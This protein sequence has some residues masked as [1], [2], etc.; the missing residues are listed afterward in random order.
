MS[1]FGPTSDVCP[2]KSNLRNVIRNR[3]LGG[4]DYLSTHT[5]QSC[6]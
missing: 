1:A 3:S 2:A 5:K 6:E 4:I